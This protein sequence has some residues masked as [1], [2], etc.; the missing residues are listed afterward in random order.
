MFKFYLK[1]H[2]FDGH[3]ELVFKKVILQLSGII[4]ISDFDNI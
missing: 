4:S 2:F 3:D 1:S